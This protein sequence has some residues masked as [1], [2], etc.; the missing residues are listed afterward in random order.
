MTT[1]LQIRSFAGEALAHHVPAL[2]ELRI[3]V[4]R[5]F[6]YL[7]AGDE[8]YERRYLRT[9]VDSPR[10]V[11]VLAFDGERVVGASTAIPLA[12]E[13]ESIQR[14]F[15]E[16]GFAIDSVFY[17]GE[18]VL[19]PEYRGRGAGVRFFAEREAAAQRGGFVWAA[20]CAVDRPVDHPRRPPGYVP[21]DVFW[22][23]RGYERRPDLTTT[24]SWQDLDESTESAKPMI[25]WLRR[26]DQDAA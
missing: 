15:R 9:Y 24:L 3:R 25:F 6:P 1:P 7:Y 18:S 22:R 10:A 21:L 2:A 12:E 11:M 4:F 23:K 17:F 13:T 19:L 26:L 16:A 14:P 8:A 20:F 5:D